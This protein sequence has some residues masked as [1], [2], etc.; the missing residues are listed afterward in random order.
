LQE[1]S[2]SLVLNWKSLKNKL[3]KKMDDDNTLIIIIISF[4]VLAALLNVLNVLRVKFCIKR[5][6]GK[7]GF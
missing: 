1:K 4:V 2:S 7:I 6:A 3:L 5:T